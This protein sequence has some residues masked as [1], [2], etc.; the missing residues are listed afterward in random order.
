MKE[1]KMS[2]SLGNIYTLKD[3]KE[4]G[5]SPLDYRYF[6]LLTHYRAPLQFSLDNLTAAKTA[7]DRLRRKVIEIKKSTPSLK[8]SSSSYL[9]EFRNAIADD[10]NIPLAIQVLYKMLDDSGVSSEE[11]LFILEDFDKVLGLGIKDFKEEKTEVPAEI[12]E[13]VNKRQEAKKNKD[14]KE[15]DRLRELINSQGYLVADT[16]QGPVVSKK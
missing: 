3:L 12:L 5:F 8:N 10:L 13:L 14:F 9:A 1:G 7:L 6:C 4:K 11:K 15:S 2:K 16:P